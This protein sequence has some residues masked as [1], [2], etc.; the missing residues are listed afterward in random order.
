MEF[1]GISFGFTAPKRKRP[2][3][4]KYEDENPSIFTVRNSPI[5]ATKVE[6]DQSAKTETLQNLEKNSATATAENGLIS[7]DLV[8]SQ[9]SEPQPES[10]RPEA[11]ASLADSKG[12]TEESESGGDLGVAKEEPQSPRKESAAGLR[13]EDDRRDN[14]TVTKVLVPHHLNF[15]FLFKI[16]EIAASY[17]FFDALRSIIQEFNTI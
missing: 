17:L 3:P 1:C 11:N 7:Y 9:A 8:S 12:L 5:S 2:R 14:T 6:M 16:G 10:V 15:F 4:V 13:L